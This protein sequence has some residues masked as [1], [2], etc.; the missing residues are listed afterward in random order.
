MHSRM[1][2]TAEAILCSL[3]RRSSGDA[4]SLLMVDLAAVM[5]KWQSGAEE[6]GTYRANLDHYGLV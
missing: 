3:M 1:V 6:Q 4:M 5:R 2:R